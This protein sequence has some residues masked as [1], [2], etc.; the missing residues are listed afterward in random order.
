VPERG[1]VPWPSD[2]VALNGQKTA[3]TLQRLAYDSQA[4]L[5][6]E[7]EPPLRVAHMPLPKSRVARLS[8]SISLVNSKLQEPL[9]AFS[10]GYFADCNPGDDSHSPI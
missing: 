2:W 7:S 9:Q 10:R 6:C 8:P 1:L 5:F 3:R 4:P